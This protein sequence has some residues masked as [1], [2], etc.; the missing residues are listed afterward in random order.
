[1]QL[2]TL[3]FLLG[4]S[5]CISTCIEKISSQIIN[6]V[7]IQ[8]NIRKKESGKPLLYTIKSFDICGSV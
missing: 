6:Q 3:E 8:G 1:M 5:S 4:N 7:K 2:P